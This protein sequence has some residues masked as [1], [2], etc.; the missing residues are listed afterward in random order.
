LTPQS[1]LPAYTIDSFFTVDSLVSSQQA[2]S[3]LTFLA[4][5]NDNN[6]LNLRQKATR[7]IA[8]VSEIKLLDNL[9]IFSN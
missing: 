9:Q 7:E 2:L 6:H 4:L 1:L 3:K 8:A 5:I